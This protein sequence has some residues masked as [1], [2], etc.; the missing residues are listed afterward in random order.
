MRTLHE[1]CLCAAAFLL[2][3]IALSAQ[4]INA[5][6]TVLDKTY[7]EPVIGAAVV[8]VG[9]DIGTITD[10]DGK[11]QLNVPQGAIL[12]FLCVGMKTVTMEASEVMT[13][14]L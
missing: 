1:F 4:D 7:G 9:T 3:G 2:S 8:A 10:I 14:I 6:G 5:S 11:F 12:Q 13:I